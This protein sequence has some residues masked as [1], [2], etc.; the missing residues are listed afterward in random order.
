MRHTHPLATQAP[1]FFDVSRRAPVYASLPPA[2]ATHLAYQSCG[3]VG[4]Q[5]ML[6]GGLRFGGGTPKF[7][8]AVKS[9]R[10]ADADAATAASSE[11]PESPETWATAL[12]DMPSAVSGGH[13]ATID[14]VLYVLGGYETLGVP[15]RHTLAFDARAR[16]WHELPPVP[17]TCV[18]S[19]AALNGRLH[20]LACRDDDDDDDDDNDRRASHH[21]V[22]DPKR[23]EWSVPRGAARARFDRTS[24][25]ESLSQIT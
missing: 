8:N 9:L 6:C 23:R 2:A 15:M 20:V 21:V 16:E 12:P 14:G 7:E 24:T 17:G 1:V 13:T 4:G 11:S 19:C 3:V 22:F 5:F 18:A 25:L 10:V